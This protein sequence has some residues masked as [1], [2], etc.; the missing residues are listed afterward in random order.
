MTY[1]PSRNWF[2]LF[3]FRSPLLAESFLF[4]GVL[5]CFSSPGSLPSPMCSVTVAWACPHAGFPIRI[6]S[7]LTVAHTSPKLVAVY[8]VLHRHT[9]P[10]HPPYALIHFLH[11]HLV[12][13]VD[14]EKLSVQVFCY[15]P[16]FIVGYSSVKVRLHLAAV[17]L[18]V[19]SFGQFLLP[20]TSQPT[21]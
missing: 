14:P 12:Q 1:N 18:D 10:R 16:F 8:H 15:S 21:R 3:R 20:A 4:L 9:M 13:I 2:G 19:A 17:V 7:V 6:S 11:P 5:R